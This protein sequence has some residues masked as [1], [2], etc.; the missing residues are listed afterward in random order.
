[1]DITY[2]LYYYRCTPSVPERGRFGT[3]HTNQRRWKK[4]RIPLLPT[5]SSRCLSHVSRRSRKRA[6]RLLAGGG[7]ACPT[8][9][10]SRRAPFL[11][12]GAR[13]G[14][15]AS[16][17]PPRWRAGRARPHGP[18]CLSRLMKRRC[19][20]RRR[21]IRRWSGNTPPP[22][23]SLSLRRRWGSGSRG[24]PRCADLGDGVPLRTLVRRRREGKRGLSLE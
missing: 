24:C 3:K 19:S 20:G 18:L 23:G 10:T 7:C 4:T 6:G 22:R 2:Y 17:A 14:L 9:P 8:D 21:G 15:A 16:A 1:M 5:S 11:L 12:T 13:T